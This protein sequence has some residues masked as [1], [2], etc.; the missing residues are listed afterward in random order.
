MLFGHSSVQEARTLNAVLDNF[1]KASGALINKVKSQIFF[2]NTPPTSQR[3][4]ARIL[5]FS[6]ASLPSKYL[7][8]PLIASAIKHS[9]WT[10]LLEKLEAKLF[11]WTHRALNMACRI[12]LI[13]AVL[14][15]MSL[16]LFSIMA[17]PKWVLKAIKQLQ[18]NFLWG[19]SGSN[20]KWA[21]VKWEKA[22]LPKNAGGIGLRDPE[23]SNMIMGAKIWWKWLSYPNTP[24]A[25]LWTT[26]YA[27][28]L[29][30]EESIRMTEIN[31]RDWKE[32]RNILLDSPEA[33]H[34]S[35]SE[36]LKKR[37]ILKE[38]GKD[39]L[40]WGYEEKGTFTTKEAYNI[41]L[42]DRLIKDKLWEKIWNPPIWPKVSTFLWLL[43]H[44]RILSWDNLRKRKFAGPSICLNCKLDEESTVH[45]MQICPFGRRLWEKVTFRCRKEGRVLGDIN[46]T[47]RNWPQKPYQCEILNIIWQIAPGILMW[48]IWKEQ[49]RRIFKDQAMPMEQ[50]WKIIHSNIQETLSTK[51]WSQED[52]PSSP[53]EQAIWNN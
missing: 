19:S 52:F 7:G 45:L 16:Y 4:I 22:C 1:S 31:H 35:L 26:K 23:H 29:P 43:S 25:R 53:Q 24:W 13:K 6:V 20:R 41:I 40:R 14:Q 46:N 11:L 15:S 21:L 34:L 10:N 18:R 32:I 36:E 28:N 47:L 48:N 49:N 5:G 51:C 38:A 12:V 33:I 50:V 9:S 17:A 44:N 27:S 39:K 2:F 37:K 8:A 42:K 3:A 30:L